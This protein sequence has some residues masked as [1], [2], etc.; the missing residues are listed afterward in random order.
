MRTVVD[1]FGRPLRT[2]RISVTDKCNLRCQYCMPEEDYVWLGRDE[3]LS[4]EEIA[5]L[6][7]VF[8]DLG[9]DRLRLTGGEPLLRRGLPDLM[10]MLAANPAL[11]DLSLTTNGV[12][13]ARQA[14]ALRDAGLRRVT[15]SL[16][17]LRPDRFRASTRRA[18]HPL[19]LEGIS[20]ARDAG[21]GPLKLNAVVIRG[22]NDDELAELIEFGRAH[23]AEVRFI[24][25]MDVGGATRWEPARVVGRD[26]MLASLERRYGCIEALRERG[27][28]PAERYVLP[29]GTTFGIVASTTHPFCSDCD[30]ARLTTDGTWLLCLYAARGLDLRELVRGGAG[31]EVL[32]EAIAGA[33]RSRR[34][35]GAEVRKALDDRGERGILVPVEDLRRD[36][37]RE[38]HVRGG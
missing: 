38:M 33:W 25:Y 21:L 12:L 9:V 34:D 15:V 10:R 32:A 22:F 2:L 17:T 7:G 4:F 29:D 11:R 1:A 31:R 27:S 23:G 6:A 5:L 8:T 35:R 19:V 3:I 28:A 26:E 14:R 37:R 18:A 20:A 24:E 36:P 16:D 13:L 30:R